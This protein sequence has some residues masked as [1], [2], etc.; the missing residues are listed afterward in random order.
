MPVDLSDAEVIDNHCHGFTQEGLLAVPPED[1]E[2]RLTLMGMGFSSSAQSDPE[3]WGRTRALTETTALVLLARRWMAS[4]LACEPTAEAVAE[5]RREA[6]QSDPTAYIRALLDEEHIVGLIADEGYPLPSIPSQEFER[7]VGGVPVH[8]VVRL[9][10]LIV[11]GRDGVDS[12]AALEDAVGGRLEAAADDPRTVAFKSIIAYRTGLDVGSQ[13]SEEAA[14]GFE[15]WRSGGWAETQADAKPVRDRLLH[16]AADV[17]RRRDL[18]LHIHT[19][20]GDPDIDLARARPSNLFPFLRD[21]ARQPI[22]L[23]HGGHPWSH[24]AAYIASLMPNVFVDLSVLIPWASWA[25]ERHLF[26][27][28]GAVP[29]SKLLYGSDQ[30]SEPEVFWISARLARQALERA[31][32]RAVND[33]FLSTAQAEEIGRGILSGNT[34]ALHRI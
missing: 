30:A 25:V 26:E 7:A 33:D 15:R 8:R 18:A 4:R 11:E 2:T 21:H 5:A 27:L 34:R 9:E 19:G 12:Y 29:T 23:I 24:E 16:A 31:L 1:F 22:V 10:Q 32:G 14:S 20:D 6:I 13:S 3:T 17:A 28:I